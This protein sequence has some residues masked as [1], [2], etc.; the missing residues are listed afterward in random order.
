MITI[1]G[2]FMFAAKLS[3]LHI[4]IF[5]GHQRRPRMRL[6]SSANDFWRFLA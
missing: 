3:A 2:G 6:S 1:N 5:M 4:G